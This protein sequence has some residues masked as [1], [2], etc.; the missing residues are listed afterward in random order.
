MRVMAI[1]QLSELAIVGD[2]A[3]PRL[4]ADL[5]ARRG[6]DLWGLAVRL[7]LSEEQAAD[8][9]Q[10]TL[11]RLWTEVQRDAWV[12][13]PD[14]WAFRTLYHLAMD[15]HRLRRRG[16]TLLDRLRADP[17]RLAPDLGASDERLAVWAEVDRL[18][19]RQR[20]VV[21]LRYRADLPYEEIGEV[22]GMSASAARSHATQ[23]MATL[24]RRLGSTGG[25]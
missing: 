1:E 23:A 7:G 20:A 11:L 5:H 8:A 22:L 24:R 12:Q 4:V 18:P 14:A 19:V 10:E 25:P 13:S 16:H 6:R 3:D 17:P 2:G 15:Q 9:V 21:Y